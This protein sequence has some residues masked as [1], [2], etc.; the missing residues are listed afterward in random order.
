RSRLISV[1]PWIPAAVRR[2]RVRWEYLE[3]ILGGGSMGRIR[4]RIRV[5]RRRASPARNHGWSA[6]RRAEP[7]LSAAYRHAGKRTAG[8]Q[9]PGEGPNANPGF[10]SV[11]QGRRRGSRFT[12]TVTATGIFEPSPSLSMRTT[13]GVHYFK[14]SADLFDSAAS[15]FGSAF[16]IREQ[17]LRAVTSTFVLVLQQQF[18]WRDRL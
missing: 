9:R 14:N 13:V 7:H 8:E 15:V 11:A 10:S 17:R 18:A 3:A 6:R 1:P 2:E 5:A 12:G 16:S 4:R